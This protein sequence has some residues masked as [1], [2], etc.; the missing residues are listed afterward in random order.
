[1]FSD[2]RNIDSVRRLIADIRDYISL[3]IECGKYD[4][5]SK[6]AV[7]VSVLALGALLLAAAIVILF[8]LS[9][10]VAL[11]V[12]DSVG[13]LGTACALVAAFYILVAVV[14]YALRRRII[15]QPITNLLGHLFL[16][17][18]KKEEK[19]P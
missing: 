9:Y 18:V 3:R 16:N 17:D 1:M 5:V 2:D 15:V 8:F 6:L 13:G 4:L 7:L 12:A 10:A 19:K 14:L 11:A